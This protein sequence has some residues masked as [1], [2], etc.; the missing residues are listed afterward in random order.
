MREQNCMKEPPNVIEKA[1]EIT[2]ESSNLRD[3][4]PKNFDTHENSSKTI[5]P[6][7]ISEKLIYD[8]EMTIS[9]LKKVSMVHRDN[10]PL[11]YPMKDALDVLIAMNCS[12]DIPSLKSISVDDAVGALLA[13]KTDDM[14]GARM[15]ADEYH[16][17]DNDEICDDG[18][19]DGSHSP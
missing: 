7:P 6:P 1:Y 10:N 4:N 14:N 2:Q 11:Y 9:Q 8:V 5:S 13:I 12:N 18:V 16:D 15:V 19:E 17:N 3:F